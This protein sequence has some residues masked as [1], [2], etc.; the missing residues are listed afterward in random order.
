MEFYRYLATSERDIQW[1]IHV[2]GAG[3]SS[4]PPF[5]TIYPVRA[6]PDLYQFGWE[7]GRVLGEFQTVYITSGE[8]EFE[9][10]SGGVR[11]VGAGALLL[12]FP[13]EWHRY[14]PHYNTG[15]DEYWV[16]FNGEIPQRLL[17]NGFVSTRTPVLSV[18]SDERLLQFYQTI[19]DNVRSEPIGYQQL[20]ASKVLLILATA[21]SIQRSQRITGRHEEVVAHAKVLLQQ[22]ENVQS[23]DRLAASLNLSAPQF[24]RVFK[25]H[26]G[27]SPHQYYNQMRMNRARELLQETSLTVKEV[28]AQLCYE[29]PYHFSKAFKKATGRS[30]SHWRDGKWTA[31]CDGEQSPRR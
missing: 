22:P 10:A 16:S 3:V 19:L 30:P 17:R 23:I 1:G 9:S 21:F 15:W 2:T 8:G 13:G 29:S 25:E 11:R 27:V 6:H 26:T 4:V 18:G 14:R 20:I 24:R 28:A 31:E 5:S 12:I 7:K